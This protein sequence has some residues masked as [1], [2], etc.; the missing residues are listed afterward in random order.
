MKLPKWRRYILLAS[1]LAKVIF[2]V[3]VMK[4]WSLTLQVSAA[5]WEFSILPAAML[6]VLLGSRP[7]R[8]SF[9][10][11]PLPL[12]VPRTMLHIHLSTCSRA[13]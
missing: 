6:V 3:S 13:V 2:H 7:T 8:E 9:K 10:A 12:R 1:V 4:S 5:V 11:R